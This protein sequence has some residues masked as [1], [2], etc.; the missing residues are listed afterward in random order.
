MAHI[1]N[2]LKVYV[3]NLPY[4][5]TRKELGDFGRT[6]G[7][8]EV[9]ATICHVKPHAASA[10]HSY[11]DEHAGHTLRPS[12]TTSSESVKLT[13]VTPETQERLIISYFH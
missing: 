7:I 12:S 10:M 9:C 4:K 1:S 13:S 5:W 11:D 6:V 8:V 2:P 3:G